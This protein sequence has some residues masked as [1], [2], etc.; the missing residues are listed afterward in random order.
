LLVVLTRC[1]VVLFSAKEAVDWLVKNLRLLNRAEAV[2]WGR[3]L[4]NR[5]IIDHVTGDWTFRDQYLFF[6]FIAYYPQVLSLSLSLFLSIEKN[7]F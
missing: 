2:V 7:I 1:F 3:E 5:G 6:K 4:Q